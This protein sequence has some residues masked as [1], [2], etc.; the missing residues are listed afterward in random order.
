M[1]VTVVLAA[2]TV[3]AVVDVSPAV[4][5][6]VAVAVA[7]GVAVA[8]AVAV[9]VGVSVAVAVGLAVAV[10]VG[11]GVDVG[12]S[13]GVGV[14]VGSGWK[15]EQPASRATRASSA[16]RTPNEGGIRLEYFMQDYSI[17]VDLGDGGRGVWITKDRRGRRHESRRRDAVCHARSRMRISWAFCVAHDKLCALT[18]S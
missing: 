6:I 10:A 5:V 16:M 15:A 12:V 14:A 3:T 8:V 18:A 2:D 13:V 4:A 7:V 9:A 1:G 17:V 11:D